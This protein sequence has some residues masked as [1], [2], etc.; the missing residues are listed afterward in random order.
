MGLSQKV[1]R[2]QLSSQKKIYAIIALISIMYS[3]L[4]EILQKYFF[5]NRYGSIYDFVAD[6]IGCALGMFLFQLLVQKK[7][8]NLKKS[9]DNI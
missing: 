5:T 9:D 6:I 1:S 8:K 2:H 7:L 3:G 4:T